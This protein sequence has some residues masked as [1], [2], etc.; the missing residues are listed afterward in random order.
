M[1]TKKT[2]TILNLTA[3]AIITIFIAFAC[4]EKPTEAQNLSAAEQ[5]GQTPEP[6]FP[7]DNL[8]NKLTIDANKDLS[9]FNGLSFKSGSY[10]L[11]NDKRTI[12]H[13]ADVKV[14]SASKPY[15]SEVTKDA[16]GNVVG[17]ECK[18]YIV[19][20]ES[21]A[22]YHLEGVRYAHR[23]TAKVVFTEEG[24]L[25]IKF[26][27]Y[28]GEIIYSL[29]GKTSEEPVDGPGE[30]VGE[31]KL[32]NDKYYVSVIRYI[33]QWWYKFNDTFLYVKDGNIYKTTTTNLDSDYKYIYT[34]PPEFSTF[35]KIYSPDSPLKTNGNIY[36]DEYNLELHAYWG[37]EGYRHTFDTTVDGGF[38]ST[39]E[40]T[41]YS[42]FSFVVERVGHSNV[43]HHVM[44]YNP[45]IFYKEFKKN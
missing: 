17:E 43:N 18:F 34:T 19:S 15:I 44:E 36:V 35:E 40:F 16:N 11:Y 3:I 14:D 33:G 31:S 39:H 30:V 37:G 28:S 13:Y 5:V 26:S 29:I 2:K 27:S 7:S 9:Q 24:Y 25:R 21:G 20:N 1:L 8:A 6:E 32:P 22:V 42:N 4:S 23:I 38:E 41:F 12:Y 10:I 45:V